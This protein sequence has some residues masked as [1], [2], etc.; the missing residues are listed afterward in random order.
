MQGLRWAELVGWVEL[1]R[2]PSRC[3]DSSK[4]K[5]RVSKELRPSYG[6]TF[7]IPNA[8]RERRRYQAIDEIVSRGGATIAEWAVQLVARTG[9]IVIRRLDRRDG[10]SRLPPS[11]VELRRTGRLQPVLRSAPNSRHFHSP[12]ACLKRAKL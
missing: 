7:A 6:C 5:R 3:G 10:G 4:L 8:R 11:L 2:N 1:L 9:R 12:S